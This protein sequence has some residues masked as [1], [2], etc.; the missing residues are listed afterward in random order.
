MFNGMDDVP[1]DRLQHAFGAARD[2]PQIL[3]AIAD[4]DDEALNEL[5]GNIWHQGT[6]YEATPFAVPFV[7]EL[8]DVNGVDHATVLHLLSSIARDSDCRD[9]SAGSSRLPDGRTA[10]REQAPR[11]LRC[12]ENRQKEVRAVA[13]LAIGTC[14]PD[15]HLEDALVARLDRERTGLVR[16]S[17]LLALRPCSAAN[18]AVAESRFD[19]TDAVVRVAA[20]L[21][22]IS[23]STGPELTEVG[24]A[25]A[26]VLRI[27]LPSAHALLRSVP[28]LEGSD[29]IGWVLDEIGERPMLELQLLDAWMSAADDDVRADAVYS[30][31]R[32]LQRSPSITPELVVLLME[33]LAH[34]TEIRDTACRLLSTVGGAARVASDALASLL[35]E[36]I[37]R[38]HAAL[39]ALRALC[40]LE[41]PRGAAEVARQLGVESIPWHCLPIDSLGPWAPS[42]LG[43][44]ID[45][46]PG[47]PDG[48]TKIAVISAISRYGERARRAVPLIRRELATHPHIATSVLG[49]FGPHAREALEDLRPFLVD[50]DDIVRVNAARAFW[51]IAGRDDVALPILAEAIAQGWVQHALAALA[52]LGPVAARIAPQLPPLFDSENEW[53]AARAAIAYWHLVGDA[54]AVLPTLTRHVVPR[55]VGF[56]V[57]TCL[58]DMGAEAVESLAA[59]REAMSVH[60]GR[61]DHREAW[62]TRCQQAIDRITTK[63]D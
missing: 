33:S 35:A 48:N 44:L 5:F 29:P 24:L 30:S 34:N 32:S 38:S 46:L 19:D 55:P 8:L 23:S 62:E 20:A 12:L 63:R 59:L 56:E 52:E 60:P 17:V 61:A 53:V 3:R 57:V 4:G 58:A 43:P 1:W 27:D 37:E 49:D 6:V 51:R 7:A 2:V 42:C 39:Y 11:L 45:A 16:A 22:V 14:L 18:I 36:P 25:A 28:A 13:A 50:R 54:R 40:D 47:A 41:D 31:E 15:Q 10:V 26:D 9:T 21:A